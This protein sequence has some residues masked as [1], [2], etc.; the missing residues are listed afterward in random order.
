MERSLDDLL[1]HLTH[2][3]ACADNTSVRL[4]GKAKLYAIYLRPE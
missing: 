3:Y 2:A 4:F 1:E